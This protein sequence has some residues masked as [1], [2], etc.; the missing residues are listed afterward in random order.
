MYFL[1]S[2]VFFSRRF[3][4]RSAGKTIC[5]I[6]LKCQTQCFAVSFDFQNIIVSRILSYIYLYR[7]YKGLELSNLEWKLKNIRDKKKYTLH[8]Y[9][10]IFL[11][12]HEYQEY[13]IS[14]VKTLEN[15]QQFL[16]FRKNSAQE[17]NSCYLAETWI[18]H[19]CN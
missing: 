19:Q 9:S 1:F 11:P 7:S 10:S 16:F 2:Q 6:H 4:S 14:R 18:G 3:N 8:V 13:S 5:T 12:L 15:M 17:G